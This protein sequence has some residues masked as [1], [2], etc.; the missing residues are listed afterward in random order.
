M[1]YNYCN[2]FS[3][4]MQVLFVSGRITPTSF[5]KFLNKLSETY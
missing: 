5:L 1:D 4:K 3:P 2:T